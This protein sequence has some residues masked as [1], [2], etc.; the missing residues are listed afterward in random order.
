MSPCCFSL[1]I[2][3]VESIEVATI[4][5]DTVRITWEPIEIPDIDFMEDYSYIIYYRDPVISRETNILVPSSVSSTYIRNLKRGAVYQFMIAVSRVA[6]REQRIGNR[7][8][9][10]RVRVGIGLYDPTDSQ[11]RGM[12][13]DY[14][15]CM[16][17]SFFHTSY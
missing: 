8:S 17:S 7:L 1:F 2:A 10:Q 3:E 15:A 11:D 14:L 6:G 4:G 9:A 16:G 12:P 5:P 13:N